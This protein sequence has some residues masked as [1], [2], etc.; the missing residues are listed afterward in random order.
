MI[1][2][3]KYYASIV[4]AL[5]VLSQASCLKDEGAEAGQYGMAGFEGGNFVSAA[6]AG[7]N[8][9]ALALESKPGN[10]PLNLFT[11][12][13]ENVNKAPE[14][15]KVTF[16]KDDAAVTAANLGLTLLPA[17]VLTFSSGAPEVTIAKGTRVSP[18]FTAQIN[19]STLDPTKSYGLAF[20]IQSVSLAGV[21][22]P[23][24]LKTVI[25]K[26]ALKNRWDGVYTVTG[27]MTDVL[28]ASL[29]QYDGWTAHLETTGPTTCAVRDM[30]LTGDIFHPIKNG[31]A[32]SYY[33]QFG[34]IVTFDPAN[35]KVTKVES[36]YV[37]SSLTRS[38]GLDPNF[39]SKVLLPSK[40][41][42]IKYLMF[43]PSVVALPNPRVTFDETW[44]YKSARK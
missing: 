35:D 20:T 32:N 27:P 2:I 14:D 3:S 26:I 40:N 12:N 5:L 22:I 38:A 42:R 17:S 19:T 1:K 16:L 4:I 15:I 13:Y 36:P 28:V 18:A 21:S 6:A 33:G 30:T 25:Y 11:V 23:A 7:K 10:Q 37:P 8:P 24:N 29:T 43:Q 9:N 31:G 34:M 39:D 41:I 44:T